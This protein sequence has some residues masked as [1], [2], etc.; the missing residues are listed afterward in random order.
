MFA[1]S[2]PPTDVNLIF[3]VI[4]SEV[5]RQPNA[6]EELALSVA[7]GTPCTSAAPTASRLSLPRI[8]TRTIRTQCAPV[9]NAKVKFRRFFQRIACAHLPYPYLTCSNGTPFNHNVH[10]LG[11]WPKQLMAVGSLP[12]QGGSEGPS[13][14]LSYSMTL[15]RLLD[16]ITPFNHNVHHRGLWTEAAYGLW[17]FEASSY[18]AAPKDLPS[19]FVQHDDHSSS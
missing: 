10:H 7:D 12:L 17:Q 5:R 19:S 1:R 16:T 18:K 8:R 14:H 3:S 13:L 9:L 15:S 4:L 2:L 11:F 6:V